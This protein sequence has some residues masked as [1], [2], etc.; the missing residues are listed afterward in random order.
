MAKTLGVADAEFDTVIRDE[1]TFLLLGAFLVQFD[2]GRT[3]P[4][5]DG[6]REL[7]AAGHSGKMLLQLLGFRELERQLGSDRE[8]YRAL[9][10]T[11]EKRRQLR[12]D[13][14]RSGVRRLGAPV[15]QP[16]A[17]TREDLAEIRERDEEELDEWRTRRMAWGN[18]WQLRPHE[19]EL[20]AG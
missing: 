9:G 8:A 20:T 1:H 13:L 5:A 15:L 4:S 2:F 6:L 12:R 7:R 11:V 17:V 18:Y 19:L 3:A 14:R 16:L 10:I